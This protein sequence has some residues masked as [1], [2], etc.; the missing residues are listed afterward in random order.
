MTAYAPISGGTNNND[1]PKPANSNR[2]VIQQCAGTMPLRSN[3][4]S[5]RRH[6]PTTAMVDLRDADWTRAAIAPKRA[7]ANPRKMTVVLSA[8]EISRLGLTRSSRNAPR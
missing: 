8:T 2:S 3:A 7:E 1:D 5:D 4:A 6:M